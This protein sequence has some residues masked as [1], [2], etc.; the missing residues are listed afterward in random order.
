VFPLGGGN[1]AQ[2]LHYFNFPWE[3]TTTANYPAPLTICFQGPSGTDPTVFPSSRALR[4]L[5]GTLVDQTIFSGPNAPNFATHTVC[6]QTN[7]LSRFVI[8]K[9]GGSTNSVGKAPP[10]VGTT[11]RQNGISAELEA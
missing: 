9:L 1:D 2:R 11:E 7:S 8:A 4:N 10:R 6:G 3:I 5:N